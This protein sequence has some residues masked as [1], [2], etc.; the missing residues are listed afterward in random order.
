MTSTATTL[1]RSFNRLST[2]VISNLS[3]T[4]KVLGFRRDSS[5]LAWQA[6]E[7]NEKSCIFSLNYL[8]SELYFWH[9]HRLTERQQWIDVKFYYLNIR[10]TTPKQTRFC[11]PTMLRV[12]AV[13]CLIFS[14][15]PSILS[16]PITCYIN[17]SLILPSSATLYP[18]TTLESCRCLLLQEQVYGFQYNSE[19]KSCYAIGNDSS[20]TN[21]QITNYSQ[22]C[23]LES[24]N[25]VRKSQWMK[26]GR[27]IQSNHFTHPR[28]GDMP[29]GSLSLA[30]VFVMLDH[31]KRLEHPQKRISSTRM[32]AKSTFCERMPHCMILQ[33]IISQSG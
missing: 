4:K 25:T 11:N 21:L 27:D 28:L 31:S 12:S 30:L 5:I 2:D 7:K 3:R 26:R 24:I 17:T 15:T 32:F 23:F 6:W 8:L 1:R 19:G 13:F 14:I 20:L 22:V 18:N 29:P 9:R 16:I 10:E 33:K